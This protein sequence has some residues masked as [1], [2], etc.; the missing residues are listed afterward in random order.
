MEPPAVLNRGMTACGVQWVGVLVHVN[1]MSHQ[2]L[3]LGDNHCTVVIT[4]LSAPVDMSADG[5]NPVI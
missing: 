2:R 4:G 5:L 1:Y 3:P